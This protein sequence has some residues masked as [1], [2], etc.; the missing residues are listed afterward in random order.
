M[1]YR[2]TMHFCG[3]PLHDIPLY[4][5]ATLPFMGPV[6]VWIGDVYRRIRGLNNPEPGTEDIEI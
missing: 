4:L 3:N 1:V 6:F 2:D 5:V